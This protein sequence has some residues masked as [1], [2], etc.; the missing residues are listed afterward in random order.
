MTV[1]NVHEGFLFPHKTDPTK[2][3]TRVNAWDRVKKL[4][5]K[6]GVSPDKVSPHVFRHSY[7]T[8]LLDKGCDMAIVQ[9]F[10]GHEDIATTRIYAHVTQTNKKSKFN[11][12]H[13]LATL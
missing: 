8:H 2:H 9:E 5:A 12:F 6:A 11:Q 10:L 7:A 4:A 3:M 13:P 1:Y